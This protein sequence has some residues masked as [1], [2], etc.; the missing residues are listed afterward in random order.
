MLEVERGLLLGPMPWDNLKEETTLSRRFP[1]EQSGNVRPID[2]L[3]Q[4][5]INSTVT[6]YEQATV[7]GPDVT[8]AFA[9]L[10]MRCL[11]DCGKSTELVGRSLDLA[12]AYC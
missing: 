4:S 9:T 5:R 2:D 3:S 8:S 10:L 11:A 12:S 7:D 6:C 1:V